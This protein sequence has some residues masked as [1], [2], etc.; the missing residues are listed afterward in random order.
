M[1]GSLYKRYG[2]NLQ[3]DVC[4]FNKNMESGALDRLVHRPGSAP[5]AYC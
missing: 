2:Y 3:L 5:I 4:S 1:G